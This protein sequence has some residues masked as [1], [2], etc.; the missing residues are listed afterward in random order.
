[1]DRR[2]VISLNVSQSAMKLITNSLP[3]QGM[4]KGYSDEI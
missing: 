2:F 4:R 3:I 1:M